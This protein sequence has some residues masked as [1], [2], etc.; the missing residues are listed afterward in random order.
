MAQQER[1][2]AVPILKLLRSFWARMSRVY[3]IIALLV[4]WEVLALIVHNELFLPRLSDVL[5]T[6][7]QHLKMRITLRED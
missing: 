4:L 7:W 2:T 3:S 6:M 5:I 1:A